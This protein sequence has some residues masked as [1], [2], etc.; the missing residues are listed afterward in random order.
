MLPDLDQSLIAVQ[1]D[2]ERRDGALARQQHAGDPVA[3]AELADP[4]TLDGHTKNGLRFARIDLT[5][6]PFDR[7]FIVEEEQHIE[8]V[9]F[10]VEQIVARRFHALQCA[11]RQRAADRAP[12]ETARQNVAGG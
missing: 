8:P 1:P 6:D 11:S 4:L 9:R 7:S 2:D 12:P 3:K 10:P 5:N